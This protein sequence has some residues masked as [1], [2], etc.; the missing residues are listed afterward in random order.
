M[1]EKA[2]TSGTPWKLILRFAVPVGAGILLQQLYNIVDT[3]IVG[4]FA[5]EATLASVGTTNSL[6]LLFLALA[7]GFSAG[8]G[9]IGAQLF[10]AKETDAQRSNASTAILLLLGMGVVSTILGIALC[11]P[12]F[13]HLLA[14]PDSL[15]GAAV[16]YFRVYCLGLVFQFGYNIIAAI[17][18]S[19]GDSK[20]SLYF[21]LIA[22]IGNVIL[23]LLFVAGFGWGA[24]GAAA[25]TGIAQAGSCIAAFLYMFRRYPNFCFRRK[26]WKFETT[27]AIKILRTGAPMALQQVVMSLSFLSIQRVVNSFG[28][29][30]TASFAVGQRL[31]TYLHVPASALQITMATFS[32]QNMGAGDLQRTKS[33]MQQAL[34]LSAF[35]TLA[36]SGV[37]YLFAYPVAGLFGLGELATWYCGQHIR[38]AAIGSVLFACYFPLL[39]LFQGSGHG[40]AAM[41]TAIG[42]LGVRA[43]SV[44][45]LSPLPFFD[46]RILWWNLY[47][48]YSAGFLIAWMYYIGGRWKRNRLR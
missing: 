14:V 2:M 35:A 45:A 36:A 27:L 11:A 40:L 3:V 9:V 5:G 16:V 1:H 28:K 38:T 21:L 12:V 34:W 17:L 44:Y 23:D 37:V 31:E 39:G 48:G 26:D 33:G 41:V 29:A 4:N 13:T 8:A 7:N 18:R 6:T 20:A 25:A 15:I 10:G 42:A 43:A 32:A 24:A 46:Y 47:F 30:M 22:S 19:V